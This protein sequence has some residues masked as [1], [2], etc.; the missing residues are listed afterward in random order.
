MTDYGKISVFAG[1]IS[2]ERGISLKSGRAVYEALKKKCKDVDFVD[3]GGDFSKTRERFRGQIVFIALHGAFGEDGTVQAALERLNVPY[4]GSGVQASMLAMDKAA[5][6][7]RFTVNGLKVPRYKVIKMDSR[8]RGNDIFETPFVVKPGNGGSSIGLSVVRDK[9]NYPAALDKAFKYGDTVI[10]EEYVSGREL[11]VGI[12]QDRPLPVIEI[13]TKHDVYDFDAKYS[14]EDTK[15]VFPDDLNNDCYTRVQECGLRAH[16]ILGCRD[17]SRVDMLLD[18][19]GNVYILEVNTIPGMTERSLLPKAARASGL[20]F[21]GL[22]I[23]LVDLAHKRR[24][25]YAEEKK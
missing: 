12:L 25:D 11:T 15:Y 23:R 16:R 14:D 1:G 22:C 13:L 3:I 9:K 8:F 10:I 2:S 20:G 4:T 7:E 19:S 5:S 21:E 18:N 6:R 24:V 17:F